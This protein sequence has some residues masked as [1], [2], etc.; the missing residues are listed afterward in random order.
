M[1]DRD[2]VWRDFLPCPLVQYIPLR[3]ATLIRLQGEAGHLPATPQV[4]AFTDL[5]RLNSRLKRLNVSLPPPA[6]IDFAREL[7]ILALDLLVREGMYRLY[8]VYF[9]SEPLAGHH[10]FTV[11][12]VRFYRQAVTLLMIDKAGRTV[13]GTRVLLPRQVPS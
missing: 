2:F 3:P 7:A 6:R 8:T 11:P 12:T 5:E 13:A 4:E 10:L 1:P 9:L